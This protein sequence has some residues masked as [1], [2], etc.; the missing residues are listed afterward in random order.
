MTEGLCA[1][2]KN[3]AYDNTPTVK[4][5]VHLRCITPDEE[6]LVRPAKKEDFKPNAWHK[7]PND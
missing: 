7:P 2:C 1:I 5:I 6:T 3:N 4:V